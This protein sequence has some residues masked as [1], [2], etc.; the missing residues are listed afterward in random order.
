MPHSVS[1]GEGFICTVAIDRCSFFSVESKSNSRLQGF[2]PGH[3]VNS[4]SV[5]LRH[6][7]DIEPIWLNLCCVLVT[8]ALFR[9]LDLS[10]PYDI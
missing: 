5:A 1:E 4:L 8:N 9:L 2:H 10:H 7:A 6:V 3:N